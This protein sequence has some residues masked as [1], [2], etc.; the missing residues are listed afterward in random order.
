MP[1]RPRR[2]EAGASCVRNVPDCVCVGS[3]YERGISAAWR[4]AASVLRWQ[5]IVLRCT[6]LWRSVRA[7]ARTLR[8]REE[9][10]RMPACRG[11]Q[12]QTVF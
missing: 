1:W 10:A 11:S 9:T 2:V 3:V 6:E 4:A 8:A 7:C 12:R 5:R